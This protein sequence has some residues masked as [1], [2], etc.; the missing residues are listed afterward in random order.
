MDQCFL[1]RFCMADHET[2]VAMELLW[3]E[4]K[5]YMKKKVMRITA[6]SIVLLC[7]L[8]AV[9]I[10]VLW[11][12]YPETMLMQ[13]TLYGGRY[14]NLKDFELSQGRLIS[15]TGDPWIEYELDR[16]TKVKVIELDF[17]GVTD[18][19]YWGEI[20]D[21]ETWTS[22]TYD[23]KNGKVFVWYETAENLK[24]LWFDLVSSQS[25]SLSVDRVVINSHVGLLMHV[26]KQMV[27][28]V[29][30]ISMLAV[31]ILLYMKHTQRE[32]LSRRNR[33]AVWGTG[34]VAVFL[35]GTFYYNILMYKITGNLLIWMELLIISFIGC[36]VMEMIPEKKKVAVWVSEMMLYAFMQMGML[37]VLSGIEFNFKSVADG[38]CNVLILML[39]ILVIYALGGNETVA[40][41]LVNMIA[42]VL[43]TANHFFYQFR[44]NPLE[45]SDF[46]MAQTALSVIENYEF[47]I[48]YTMFFCLVLEIGLICL[49]NLKIQNRVY[50]GRKRQAAIVC[51]L[52]IF[53]IMTEY[54]PS[55]GYWNIVAD[56]QS[57]GYVNAFVAYARRDM[58]LDKPAG[59][60]TENTKRILEAYQ[61]SGTKEVEWEAP[62]IIVLMN[63]SFADLPA[64]YNF[65]TNVDSM[66]YIHLLTENT[67][68]GNI[69][70]SV[71][72]GSTA[73]TE[74]EFLT[75]NTLAFLNAGSVPYMQYVK[76]EHESLASELKSLGYQTVAFHP[77]S[78]GNY[79][80][81]TVYPNLGFDE[82]L[83]Y[84]DELPYLDSLRGYV[85]DSANVKD[86]LNIY[87]TYK[88][89]TPLFIFN[90]TMQNHG[91]Y[92]RSQSEVEITVKPIDRELRYMQLMEYLSLI[93]KSD[94]AFEEL[95]AYFEKQPEKT[96]ILMFGDHQPGLD[97]EIYQAL[98][99]EDME[100]AYTV[101]FVMWANYD[102]DAEEGIYTSPNYLRA[103]LLQKAGVPLG[104]YDNFLLKCREKYPAMN[105]MGYCDRDGNYHII[106]RIQEKEGML[107]EYD[108]LQYGNMF[109][110]SME[111]EL[112]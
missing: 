105:V 85:T 70:V 107:H 76:R 11:E 112:Y 40:I 92:N 77:Q 48:D 26:L 82:F 74:Y 88:G 35:C 97:A 33:I 24:K 51:V 89:D 36:A 63:E 109:D 102:V 93:K 79:N 38:I 34:T 61:K 5:K 80:R 29:L 39:A 16:I 100:A 6:I 44:G 43:G 37:E 10:E 62:N 17:S 19:S 96:I 60:T 15:V 42:L 55:V 21:M 22:H 86:V 98:G 106:D 95:T 32:L 108:M 73:N 101:P 1:Y 54:T 27:F 52:G 110:K 4:G 47:E 71:F 14:Q 69:L 103:I 45:L 3:I 66:P 84:S 18:G 56:T 23:L 87:E 49:M 111:Q 91:G 50:S 64:V 7:I 31:Y 90:V 20:Y 75:G 99:V 9:Y 104:S 8:S 67:V 94:E 72:G 28:L 65:E 41:L 2:L 78:P 58:K 46:L 59:Y 30:V 53:M 12:L 81:N 68:K 57:I 25:I 83:S 13:E